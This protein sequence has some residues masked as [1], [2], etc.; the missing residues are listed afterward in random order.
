MQNNI[1][2]IDLAAL[3][4]VPFMGAIALG[5]I[6]LSVSVFG[7]FSFTDLIW[8]GSG[9][10]LSWA[11]LITLVGIAWVV[12]TNELDGSDYE[13]FEYGVIIVMFGLVPAYVLIPPVADFINGSDIVSFVSSLG[14]SAA[15]VY[16]SWAE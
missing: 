15:V 8:S 12:A 7:G 5:T 11:A 14:L 6:T 16:I 10:E 1:D 13:Q 2:E 3:I 9:V 4:L